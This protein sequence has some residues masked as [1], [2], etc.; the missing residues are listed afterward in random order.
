MLLV[1][2]GLIGVL[3]VVVVVVFDVVEDVKLVVDVVVTKREEMIE[4][5]HSRTSVFSQI[6]KDIPPLVRIDDL[7]KLNRTIWLYLI[8]FSSQ[9]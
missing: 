5:N 7:F 9:R 6:E 2:P 3:V 4:L 8:H 1:K